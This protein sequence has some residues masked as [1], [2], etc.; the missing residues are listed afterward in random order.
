MTND[1]SVY[2]G[3]SFLFFGIVLLI[4]FI[5]LCS[6]ADKLTKAKGYEKKFVGFKC[7][8]LGLPYFIYLAALPD[9]VLIKKQKNI[10]ALVSGH[11][12]DELDL[13]DNTPPVASFHKTSP[14]FIAV[15]VAA[16]IALTGSGIY[17]GKRYIQKRNEINELKEKLCSQEWVYTERVENSDSVYGLGLHF[18]DKICTYTFY[19]GTSLVDDDI[20]AKYNYEV[21]DGETVVFSENGY[22]IESTIQFSE[23]NDYMYISPS[24]T[25]SDDLKIWLSLSY[26]QAAY[27]SLGKI[28]D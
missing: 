16:A 24:I 7:F 10:T 5:V 26:L 25:D 8:I 13:T 19:S 3:I 6:K 15:F 28:F 18:D 22:K 17:D 20:I 9:L 11:L 12:P 27:P 1:I 4:V 14:A 2:S 23:N 21:I